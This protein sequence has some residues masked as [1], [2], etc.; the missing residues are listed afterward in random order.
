MARR[1]RTTTT[2]TTM[3]RRARRRRRSPPQQQQLRP[4]R[5][6]GGRRRAWSTCRTTRRRPATGRTSGSPC[7]SMRFGQGRRRPPPPQHQQQQRPVA[8]DD[9]SGHQEEQTQGRRSPR[10]RRGGRRPKTQRA[11]PASRRWPTRWTRCSQRSARGS[12]QTTTIL[13]KATS[14]MPSRRR[15]APSISRPCGT[16]RGPAG[17]LG[18]GSRQESGGGG[19]V[20]VHSRLEGAQR[21][22]SLLAL[23]AASG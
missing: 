3:T 19:A 10:P 13:S 20:S 4:P 9:L 8:A 5:A 16:G 7:R 18:T 11:R 14:H 1:R 15:R 2:T 23:F 21:G 22:R 6:R 17:A 12:D